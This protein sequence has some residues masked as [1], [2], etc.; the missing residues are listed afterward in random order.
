MPPSSMGEK[1][2]GSA[3]AKSSGSVYL[4][5]YALGPLTSLSQ[6]KHMF[7]HTL[8]IATI[9]LVTYLSPVPTVARCV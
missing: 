6:S 9:V 8:G 1:E 3:K 5:I 2:K 4:H 7:V